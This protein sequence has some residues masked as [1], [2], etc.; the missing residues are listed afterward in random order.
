MNAAPLALC[1][2][3]LPSPLGTLLLVC[4]RDDRVRALDFADHLPR[5]ERLLRAHYGADGYTLSAAIGAASAAD[6]I[7]GYFR[8]ELGSVAEIRTCT[9]GTAFQRQTWDALR[10]IPP[11]KTTTYGALARALGRPNASRAVG[12]ANGANPIAIV[13]P[14]HRVI[15]ADGALTG[16]GGGLDRKRW[17]LAHERQSWPAR[18]PVTA[19]ESA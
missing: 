13:V 6:R 14:C 11:G 7:I 8:G 12:L 16:Y 3:Q 1:V 2:T 5:M 10:R 9:A 17:L 18:A 19:Y 4:D 15:G